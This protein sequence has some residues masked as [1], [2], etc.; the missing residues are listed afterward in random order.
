MNYH[1]WRLWLTLVIQFIDVHNALG[2][3]HLYSIYGYRALLNWCAG[4]FKSCLLLSLK[5]DLKVVLQAFDA[6]QCIRVVPVEVLLHSP[7]LR[8]LKEP[9]LS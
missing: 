1:V 2:L 9:S 4:H 8:V 7:V 5:F 3:N 6:Y